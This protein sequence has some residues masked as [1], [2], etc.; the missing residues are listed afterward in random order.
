VTANVVKQE[1]AKRSECELQNVL[2]YV[3]DK[4]VSSDF[5]GCTN[6]A[7]V[8]FNQI[9]VI[10]KL[11]TI[12]MWYDNE[13]AYSCRVLDLLKHMIQVDSE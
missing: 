4:C 13:M 3:T 11:I 8:D 10:D 1:I 2:H 5:I 7:V 6:S 12:G 9:H